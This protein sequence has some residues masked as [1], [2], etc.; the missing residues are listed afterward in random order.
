M[1]K[2]IRKPGQKGTRK[3]LNKYCDK[4]VC[5][6]YRYDPL[7][8][9]KYKTIELIVETNDWH[10]ESDWTCSDPMSGPPYP[11]TSI[12]GVRIGCD[13]K[14]LQSQIKS[15]GGQ[16]DSGAKLWRVDVMKIGLTERIA[17]E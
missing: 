1:V 14:Q 16:W 2:T 12:V 13:E 15:I 6:R 8:K 17:K 5:V 7:Q 3:Y 10:P 4:L 11:T 9:K